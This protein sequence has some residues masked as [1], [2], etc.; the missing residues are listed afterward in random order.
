MPFRKFRNEPANVWITQAPYVWLPAV[1]V[2][3]AIM[4]RGRVIVKR[5]FGLG[6]SAPGEM[7]PASGG[8]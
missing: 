8:T 6:K 7:G 1:F 4:G 2:L 5:G 3:L